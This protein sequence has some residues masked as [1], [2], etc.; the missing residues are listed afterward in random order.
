LDA[1]KKILPTARYLMNELGVWEDD[2][3]SVLLLYPKLLGMKISHMERVASYLLE[4]E[5][6]PETLSSIFRA[7][8]ALLTLDIQ[9][10]MVPVVEFLLSKNISNVG[11]F[12][13]RLPPILGYSVANELQPKWEFLESVVTDARFELSRFPAYFS[14]PLERVTKNRFEYLRQTKRFPVQLMAL[15][16]VLRFGDKEFAVKVAGDKDHGVAY[17]EFAQDRKKPP[18]AAGGKKPNKRRAPKKKNVP[19]PDF[20]NDNNNRAL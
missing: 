9:K 14:Y 6:A 13:S 12:I 11:R 7:F 2:L 17:R 15:D 10:N 20:S 8:P 4:L 18:A 3:P 19:P 16:Q 5:V 1:E